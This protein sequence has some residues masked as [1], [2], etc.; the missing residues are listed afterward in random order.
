VSDYHVNSVMVPL[1]EYATVAEDVTLYETV[2]SLEE[3]QEKYEETHTRYT[4]NC[5]C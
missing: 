1:A 2:L 3:T 4:W 5:R